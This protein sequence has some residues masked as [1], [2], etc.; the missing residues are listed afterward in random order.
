LHFFGFK[1]THK[2]AGIS[3][4]D[5]T[6]YLVGDFQGNLPDSPISIKSIFLLGGFLVGRLISSSI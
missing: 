5:G 1:E 4:K 2:S 6:A 3:V